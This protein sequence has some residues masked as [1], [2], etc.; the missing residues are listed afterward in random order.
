MKV[1]APLFAFFTLASAQGLTIG[2]LEQGQRI[3]LEHP[4]TVQVIK[5]VRLLVSLFIA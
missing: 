5:N 4:F 2:T 3:P 1:L